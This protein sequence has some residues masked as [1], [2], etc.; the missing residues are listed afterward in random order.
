MV[1]L[2]VRVYEKSPAAPCRDDRADRLTI[3][4]ATWV[5]YVFRGQTRDEVER[6]ASRQARV[7]PFYAA[8]IRGGSF[9]GVRVRADRRWIGTVAGPEEPIEVGRP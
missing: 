1:T 6:V 9:R 8:S 2:R 7:D 3:C 4:W 5:D